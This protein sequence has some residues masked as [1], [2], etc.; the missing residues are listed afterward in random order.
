M[1]RCRKSGYYNN[2]I[3]MNRVLRP[4]VLLV[5][6]LTRDRSGHRKRA[7]V[8]YI[9]DIGVVMISSTSVNLLEKRH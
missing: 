3:F 6:T 9:F 2:I 1:I 7:A 5:H 4:F 8:D